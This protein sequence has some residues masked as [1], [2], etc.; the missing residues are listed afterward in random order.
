MKFTN[1]CLS[2]VNNVL[3]SKV[4]PNPECRNRAFKAIRQ[5]INK[6]YTVARAESVKWMF[7]V[8][9]SRGIVLTPVRAMCNKLYRGSRTNE[10]RRALCNSVMNMKAEDS[11]VQCTR[12]RKELTEVWKRNIDV[13]NRYELRTPIHSIAKSEM[14]YMYKNYKN[15]KK[16][17]IEFLIN[18]RDKLNNKK[19]DTLNT[20]NLGQHC[21]NIDN[22][23]NKILDSV[24]TSSQTLPPEFSSEPRIYGN[25]DV[26]EEEKAALRLPPKFTIYDK[27][28]KQECMVEIETMVSKYM[29]EMRKRGD[30]DDIEIYESQSERHV[31]Q[32]TQNPQSSQPQPSPPPPPL[33]PQSTQNA[34]ETESQS[35]INNAS[36]LRTTQHAVPGDDEQQTDNVRPVR[37]S[38]RLSRGARI[39]ESETETR[40]TQQHANARLTR[41]SLGESPTPGTNTQREDSANNER[42]EQSVSPQT[43]KPEV[44]T[45]EYHYD[46]DTKTFDFR[47]LRPTDVPFNKHIFLPQN[48]QSREVTEEEIQVEF[49]SH[50]LEKSNGRVCS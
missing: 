35:H 28:D 6:T 37:R 7:K 22:D 8:M 5:I 21:E 4:F 1:A 41:Q 40:P 12:E 18:K 3:N 42:Q 2:K 9:I 24:V 25:V 38:Q 47:K 29:W 30:E 50:Q 13:L 26:S 33:A 43:P 39:T 11:Q 44:D 14:K 34:P 15:E 48:D 32:N 36:D 49:L 16:R 27:I 46:I 17:K 10:K 31:N 20:R 23:I 19:N 45:R